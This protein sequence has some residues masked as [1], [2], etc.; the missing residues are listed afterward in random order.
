MLQ[1]QGGMLSSQLQDFHCTRRQQDRGQGSAD[2][3]SYK[4]NGVDHHLGEDTISA[5]SHPIPS[6]TSSLDSK[7]NEDELRQ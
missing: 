2:S 1:G 3:M 5:H 6:P 4:E 7:F